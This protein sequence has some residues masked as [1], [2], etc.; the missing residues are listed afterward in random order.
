M[1][2]CNPCVINVFLVLL[3]V[4]SFRFADEADGAYTD[5]KERQRESVQR[6]LPL[7]NS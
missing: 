7:W 6:R 5:A 3:V 4:D 1:A 2:T